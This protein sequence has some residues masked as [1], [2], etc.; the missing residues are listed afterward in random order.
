MSCQVPSEAPS[1]LVI[2]NLLHVL[3]ANLPTWFFP[4][5][6]SQP[7]S[8]T[9]PFLPNYW[10]WVLYLTNKQASEEGVYLENTEGGDQPEE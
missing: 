6:P 10:L 2:S 1:P 3:L 5:K 4:H 9:F 8:P 7:K